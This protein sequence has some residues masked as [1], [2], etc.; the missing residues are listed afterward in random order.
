M[1]LDQ[2]VKTLKDGGSLPD[3]AEAIGTLGSDPTS[4]AEDIMLGLSYPG[5][6]RE[7]AALALYRRTGEPLPNDRRRLRVEPD[8]WKEKLSDAAE[9]FEERSTDWV[10]TTRAAYK[11]ALIAC[12]GNAREADEVAALVVTALW[13]AIR[14]GNRGL[15]TCADDPDV[16]SRYA[17]YASQRVRMKARIRQ[18]RRRQIEH[19]SARL[20]PQ[21]SIDES[22]ALEF[23]SA[24]EWLQSAMNRLS[25][26]EREVLVLHYFEGKSIRE[27]AEQ[28]ALSVVGV[29]G[30]LR[31]ARSRLREV[32]GEA[33]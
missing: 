22:H 1:T 26:E 29:H 11:G 8:E 21:V 28:L 12:R 3:L 24:V 14:A 15:A 7:Q 23:D 20:H 33:E 9:P 6:V 31:R 18:A 27:V 19:T 16:L 30:R 2:A 10:Q 25:P 4:A 5:F 32:W 13:Q 17:Y